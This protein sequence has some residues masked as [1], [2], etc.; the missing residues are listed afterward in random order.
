MARKIT[1]CLIL[2][3]VVCLVYGAGSDCELPKEVGNCKGRMKSFYFDITSHKCRLF[4]YSGCG[5]N[6]NRFNSRDECQFACHYFMELRP[7]NAPGPQITNMYLPGP[8]GPEVQPQE[9]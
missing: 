9:S 3:M 6:G 8:E 7:G 4:M 2:M 5:G 1:L